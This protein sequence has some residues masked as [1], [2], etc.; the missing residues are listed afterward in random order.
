MDLDSP[1]L[2]QDMLDRPRAGIREPGL[3]PP[4]DP[5][6]PGTLGTP[7]TSRTLVSLPQDNSWQAQDK[8]LQ[9]RVR[10]APWIAATRAAGRQGARLGAPLP[11]RNHRASC[12]RDLVLVRSSIFLSA[13]DAS[14]GPSSGCTQ[15]G[16]ALKPAAEGVR[17][18]LACSSSPQACLS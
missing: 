6:W 4:A 3:L 5:A 10:S 2:H 14:P 11:R 7:Q 15:P 17:P 13:P 18:P 16:E 1:R 8:A 12:F 9:R